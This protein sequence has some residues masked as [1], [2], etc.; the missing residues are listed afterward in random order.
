[1]QHV[2]GGELLAIEVQSCQTT[3]NVEGEDRE[4]EAQQINER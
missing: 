2:G 4:D 3:A 1:M